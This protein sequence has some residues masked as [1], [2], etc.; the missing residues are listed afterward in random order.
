MRMFWEMVLKLKEKPAPMRWSPVAHLAIHFITE[1]YR[2]CQALLD[3][4]KSM[5]TTA[6]YPILNIFEMF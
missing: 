3:P 1:G 2:F 6:S 5:L 4:C